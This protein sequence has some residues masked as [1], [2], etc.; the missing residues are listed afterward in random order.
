MLTEQI[1]LKI[2]RKHC[3]SKIQQ[4]L[5]ISII[6]RYLILDYLI[7]LVSHSRLYYL[8]Q[9]LTNGFNISWLLSWLVSLFNYGLV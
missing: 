9:S 5:I 1:I 7:R 6:L 8:I 3:S 4:Y 2:Q